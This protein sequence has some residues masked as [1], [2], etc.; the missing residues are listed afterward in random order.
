MAK[1]TAAVIGQVLQIRLHGE[2]TLD[3]RQDPLGHLTTTW[4]LSVPF[5]Y[6]LSKIRDF[7]GKYKLAL[8]QS[9]AHKY[10]YKLTMP[11]CRVLHAPMRVVF[12]VRRNWDA[13]YQLSEAQNP[14]FAVLI[15]DS[16]MHLKY[17]DSYQLNI[18]TIA[19]GDFSI[20]S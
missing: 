15:V 11:W 20:F 6:R 13:A 4:S 14:T 16:I 3:S 17:L 12:S 2:L 8:V 10:K 5:P 19:Q 1:S 7:W 18:K 9:V